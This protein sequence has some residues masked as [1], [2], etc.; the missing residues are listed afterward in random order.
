MTRPELDGGA[1]DY[2][3][4][5]NFAAS[6]E[7]THPVEQLLKLEED[8][9]KVLT[10]RTLTR[11]RECENRFG[12]DNETRQ[13]FHVVTDSESRTS[14]LI[15][16][17]DEDGTPAHRMLV[18][19]EYRELEEIDGVTETINMLDSAELVV[20]DDGSLIDVVAHTTSNDCDGWDAELLEGCFFLQ[21]KDGAGV[22]L[23]GVENT[24][25]QLEDPAILEYEDQQDLNY[26]LDEMQTVLDSVCTGS[27]HE[28]NVIGKFEQ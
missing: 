4:I 10:A 12:T 8:E 11:L 20:S 22:V 25:P 21:A 5:G 18:M 6:V 9:R 14:V 16:H 26:T 7:E 3:Y 28:P 19:R 15:T 24:L 13:S 17:I 1:F 27:Y 2:S 23:R